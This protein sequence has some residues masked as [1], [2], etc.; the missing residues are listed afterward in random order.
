MPHTTHPVGRD[1]P[2]MLAARTSQDD[3]TFQQRI[4]DQ[5]EL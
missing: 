1:A 4:R 2:A 3:A 5:F